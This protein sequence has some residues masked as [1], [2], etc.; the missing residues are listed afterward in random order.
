[1]ETRFQTEKP[2]EG[3]RPAPK[4]YAPAR[5]ARKKRGRKAG[6]AAVVPEGEQPR[7]VHTEREIHFGS[8]V[9]L[10]I[11]SFIFAGMVLFILTGYERISRAY[12]D[13][14]TINVEIDET[15]LSIAA[16]DVAIECAVT[17]QDAQAAAERFGMQYPD[18]TQY[19]PSGSAVP[20]T[21]TNLTDVTGEG[22]AAGGEPDGA[23]GLPATSPE[24]SAPP[25]G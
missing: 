24:P 20:T 4:L 16:L 7:R 10:I 11:C 6:E 15:K 3:K 18:K 17:I 9:A 1:M 25:E 13:V 5:K 22:G 21:G 8:R 23:S 19:V 2:Q 12:A 14:N